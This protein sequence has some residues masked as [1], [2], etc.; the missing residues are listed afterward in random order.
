MKAGVAAAF[1]LLVVMLH[2][3]QMVLGQTGS[4]QV[5][6]KNSGLSSMHTAVTHSNTVVFLERTNQGATSLLLPG[7]YVLAHSMRWSLAVASLKLRILIFRVLLQHLDAIQAQ[8]AHNKFVPT[9]II[10]QL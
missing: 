2:E 5:L 6:V 3:G 8:Q 7:M 4:W 10:C 1:V 9:T